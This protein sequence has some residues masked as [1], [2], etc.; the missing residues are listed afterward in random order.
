MY[1]WISF[2]G[3]QDNAAKR[4]HENWDSLLDELEPLTILNCLK[5]DEEFVQ[6]VR[7]RNSRKE[8]AECFLNKCCKL[9]EDEF[10]KAW[11]HLEK[12]CNSIPNEDKSDTEL[13][14]YMYMI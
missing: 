4:V 6:K 3:I 9:S 8:R 12:Y 13:G 11:S 5:F 10:E 1:F 2:F 14:A 7:S